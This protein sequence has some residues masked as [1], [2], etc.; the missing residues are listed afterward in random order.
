ML[1][2]E[3]YNKIEERLSWLAHRVKVRGRLNTLDLHI[4]CENFYRDL[5]NLVYG[6]KLVNANSSEQNATAIDLV[7]VNEKIV[8]QVSATN[9]IAKVQRSLDKLGEIYVGYSFKFLSIADSV[10]NI[11]KHTFNILRESGVTFNPKGDSFDTIILLRDINGL[12]IDT[13]EK[14]FQLITKELS[15]DTFDSKFKSGLAHVINKLSLID[16]SQCSVQFDSKDFDIDSKISVNNLYEFKS[17]INSYK[18]YHSIVQNIYDD[19]DAEGANKSFAVLQKI[20]KEY[21]KL[22]SKYSGDE[23]YGIIAQNLKK[24]ISQSSNLDSFYDDDLELYVDII[25]VDAF[26]RCKIFKKP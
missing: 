5:L 18:I 15:F 22:K 13:L 12:D 14:V 7:S 17:I 19:F 4:H 25:L 16:L 21:E 10:D 3:Y 2:Q 11:Q 1:R 26:I 23:L 8:I 20:N 9:T 24:Q 6:W